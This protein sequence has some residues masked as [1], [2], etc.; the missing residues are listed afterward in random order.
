MGHEL[1]ETQNW[2]WHCEQTPPV[3]NDEYSVMAARTYPSH[4]VV[5]NKSL[6][7]PDTTSLTCPKQG[8]V[9]MFDLMGSTNFGLP[10]S[11]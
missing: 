8:T 7:I 1:E 9:P 6:Q 2:Y 5:G 10:A 3:T 4:K 11:C